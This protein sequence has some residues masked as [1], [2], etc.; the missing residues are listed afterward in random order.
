MVFKRRE[1]GQA[2]ESKGFMKRQGK[3]TFFI[4]HTHEKQSKTSVWT[5]MSHG[6]SGSDMDRSLI[7]K[8]ARQCKIEKPEFERLIDC[9]LTQKDYE[10]LLVDRKGIEVPNAAGQ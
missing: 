9:S 6:N 5:M 3:H 7:A 4:Y 8:M 10:K 2:L 1:V